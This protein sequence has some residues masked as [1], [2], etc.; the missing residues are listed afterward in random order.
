MPPSPTRRHLRLSTA[1]ALLYAVMVGCGEAYIGAFGLAIGLSEI[2]VGLLASVPLLIGAVFQL[3]TPRGVRFLDSHKRWVI[4]CTLLQASAFIPLIVMSVLGRGSP[5]LLFLAAGLYWGANLATG[6]AWNTW[7]GT[8]VPRPVRSRY[9][10]GRSRIAPFGIVAGLV[11]T[12]MFLQARTA[13]HRAALFMIPFAVALLARFLCAFLHAAIDENRPIPGPEPGSPLRSLVS[14]EASASGGRLLLY[15]LFVQAATQISAPYFTPF[16][17]GQRNFPY[18]VFASILVASFMGKIIGLP[19]FGR[20]VRRFGERALLWVAGIGIIPLSAVWAI[21]DRPVTLIGLQLLAG[22]AWGAY[23]LSTFLLL[24]ETIP[25][26]QRTRLLT[27]YNLLNACCVVLGAGIG[28]LLLSRFGR[29]HNAYRVIFVASSIAR[30]AS[31]PMLARVHV[32]ELPFRT[33]IFRPLSVRPNAGG[34]DRPILPSLED[35]AK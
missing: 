33:I 10:A 12:G 15:M 21:D 18:P 25:A 35:S 30:F 1:D 28:A 11:S 9:F 26:R 34:D 4:L 27:L 2:Q 13:D 8:V 32:P 3:L 14:G 6:P 20:F 16:M 17:L 24:F 5:A 22:F 7:I 19:I 31:L 23:E 29:D